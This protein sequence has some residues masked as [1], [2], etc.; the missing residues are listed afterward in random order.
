MMALRLLAA[1]EAAQ[2]K[3][4]RAGFVMSELKLRPTGKESARLKPCPDETASHATEKRERSLSAFRSRREVPRCARD[5][6]C[7]NGKRVGRMSAVRKTPG[8]NRCLVELSCQAFA[9]GT[10]CRAPTEEEARFLCALLSL[11]L[12]VGGMLAL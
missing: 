3:A 7:A 8:R 9:P 10:A 6:S 2:R 4:L 5:D 1:G 11:C 12:R